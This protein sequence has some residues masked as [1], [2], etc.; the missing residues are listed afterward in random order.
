MRRVCWARFEGVGVITG[1][2]IK[3]L[4]ASVKRLKQQNRR[5]REKILKLER[6]SDGRQEAKEGQAQAT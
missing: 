3:S 1:S 4:M 5:L 6:G 2:Q